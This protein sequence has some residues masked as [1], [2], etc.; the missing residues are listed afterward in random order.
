M[1]PADQTPLVA[2]ST[3][4]QRTTAPQNGNGERRRGEVRC[5]I[6]DT[7]CLVGDLD[8]GEEFYFGRDMLICPQAIDKVRETGT[9]VAFTAHGAPDGNQ[10]RRAAAVL[11]VGEYYKGVLVSLPPGE[12]HGWLRLQDRAATPTWCTCG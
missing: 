11:V 3:P 2:I 5:W 1:R 7:Y 12:P 4:G 8:T 9:K 10:R 6:G